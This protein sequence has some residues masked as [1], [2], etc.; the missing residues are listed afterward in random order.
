MWAA[1]GGGGGGGGGQD[2]RPN[3]RMLLLIVCTLVPSLEKTSSIGV[4]PVSMI[5]DSSSV[6][7]DGL[8]ESRA[9]SSSFSSSAF[10]S[11]SS[12]LNCAGKE[13]RQVGTR[14]HASETSRAA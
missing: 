6:D 9:L 10:L 8:E 2:R 4:F 13:A 14:A 3:Q 1:R 7:E 12:K 5:L 11:P